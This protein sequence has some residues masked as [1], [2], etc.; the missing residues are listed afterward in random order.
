MGRYQKEYPRDENGRIIIRAEHICKKNIFDFDSGTDFF[1][2][3]YSTILDEVSKEVLDVNRSIAGKI[4]KAFLGKVKERINAGFTVK[5]HPLCVVGVYHFPGGRDRTSF[6][7][8]TKSYP[9]K[10]LYFKFDNAIRMQ[11]A[12]DNRQLKNKAKGLTPEMIEQRRK[13]LM[14]YFRKKR[15][16]KEANNK[17]KE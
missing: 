16:E 2:A 9:A 10:K 12:Y 7:R 3:D 13:N 4:V 6:G 14:D 1:L 15:Q 5:L 11:N 17:V 8:T